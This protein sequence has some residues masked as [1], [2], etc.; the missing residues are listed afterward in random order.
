MKNRFLSIVLAASAVIASIVVFVIDSSLYE[1][2]FS[3]LLGKFDLLAGFNDA[4]FNNIFNV[5]AVILQLTVIAV[6]IFLT[7][8]SIEKRR[9]S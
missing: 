3:E 5:P 8:Q 9:W 6:F 7:V 4:A 2:L 1:S